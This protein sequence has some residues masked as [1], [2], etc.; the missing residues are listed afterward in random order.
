[1]S[2]DAHSSFGAGKEEGKKTAVYVEE[3]KAA[4]DGEISSSKVV[5]TEGRVIE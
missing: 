5:F 4:A 3:L 2:A 1:M